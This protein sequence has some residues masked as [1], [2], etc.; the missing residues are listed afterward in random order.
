MTLNLREKIYGCLYGGAIGD[1]LGLGT[2]FMMPNEIRRRYPDGLHDYSQ[3]VRDAHRSQWDR[4]DYTNDTEIILRMIAKICDSGCIRTDDFAE[5][6]HE[7]YL[8][9]P[10][11]IVPQ[12]RW[13]VGQPDYLDDPIAVAERVWLQMGRINASNEALQ[14]AI[15]CGLWETDELEQ[16]VDE[17]CRITHTDTRCICA[18]TVIARIANTLLHEDRTLSKEEMIQIAD[19]IDR[20]VSPYIEM[21]D[22]PDISD[23]SL[24]DPETL[25]YVRK[26]MACAIWA[27]RHTSSPDEALEAIVM[28]GGDS[29]TNASVAMN[30]I[31][32]RD[33]FSKLP[34]HLVDGI[35]QKEQID[36]AVKRFF[37]VLEAH[38]NKDPGI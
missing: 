30:I 22:S 38:I 18:A 26:C 11:D 34:S 2:E 25:W 1:A 12:V 3:I 33:G 9:N 27:L 6:L 32:L 28:A 16:R 35:L 29:D 20:R 15:L 19:R 31:G 7:W 37:P 21:T 17:I 8:T 13:V 24:H 4:G 36:E 14:R 23:L 10:V 5:A